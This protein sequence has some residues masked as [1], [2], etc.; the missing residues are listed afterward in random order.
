MTAALT[1]ITVAPHDVDPGDMFVGSDVPVATL[2]LD[3]GGPAKRWKYYDDKGHLIVSKA[4]WTM[5]Q[6]QRAVAGG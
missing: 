4:F 1:V 2:L 6:V 5:V 3:C